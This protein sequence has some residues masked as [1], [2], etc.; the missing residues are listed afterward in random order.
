MHKYHKLCSCWFDRYTAYY[1]CISKKKS[2]I[3][4]RVQCTSIT[5]HVFRDFTVLRPITTVSLILSEVSYLS[6]LSAQV[7]QIL[8]MA[9]F[10]VLRLITTVLPKTSEISYFSEFSAQVSEIVFF[11]DLTVLQLITTESVK[12]SEISYLCEFSAEV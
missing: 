4:L 7:S 9:D 1:N 8:F 5:N 2:L 11:A 6:E 12:I 3:S 10:F